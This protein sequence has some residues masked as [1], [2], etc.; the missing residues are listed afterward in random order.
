[1]HL[2]I[3]SL[4]ITL[5]F[6]SPVLANAG[7]YKVTRVVDGDTIVINYNGK[8]EKV[9]LLCVNTPESVHPDGIHPRFH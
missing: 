1:M 5:L 4:L 3:I 6:I 2:R 9:R 7:Q 8:Y